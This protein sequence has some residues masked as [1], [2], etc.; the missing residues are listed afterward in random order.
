M[1]TELTQRLHDRFGPAGLYRPDP[2]AL[3]GTAAPARTAALLAAAGLPLQVGPYFAANPGQPLR[4][5]DWARTAGLSADGRPEAGWLRLGSDRGAELCVDGDG[6]VRAVYLAFR[7]PSVPVDDSLDAFLDNLCTL[8]ENLR[9]LAA[10]EQPDEVFRLFSAAESRMRGTD[11]RAFESDEQWWPR[12]LE[13]V[14]HTRGV[15]GYAAFKIRGRDG[16]PQILTADGSL[17]LHPEEAL[18][19]RLSAAGLDPDEVVEVYTELQACTMPGHYCALWMARAFPNAEFTHS[20][21]YGDTAAERDAGI[22]ELA[23]AL[24]A[25]E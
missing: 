16:E 11:L 1:T 4:L 19:E 12:V 25:G 9:A 23:A 21:D 24:A 20:H 18:R 5:A 15:P 10:A 22:R 6:R 3:S 17:A 7:G 13:D 14:R 2:A 8:D